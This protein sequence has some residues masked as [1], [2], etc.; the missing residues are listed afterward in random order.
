MED[1]PQLY[2]K[3]YCP[4]ETILL[5][6]DEILFYSDKMIVTR[7]K[8]LKPRPDIARG[9]SAYFMD[10]GFK[11]GKIY[12]AADQLVYWYCDIIETE[13]S[14]SRHALIFHDMLIDILVYPDGDVRILDLNELADCLEGQLVSPEFVSKA[15]RRASTLLALIHAGHFS[16][17][18]DIIN[19]YES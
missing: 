10:E 18:T 11:I 5:K 17:Y 4:E 8:T 15:L 6:D 3:R 19:S 14:L 7:W 12:N 1:Y 16:Q 9:I 13:W 2:R